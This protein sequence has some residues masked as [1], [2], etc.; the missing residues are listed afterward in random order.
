L[1]RQPGHRRLLTK[2]NPTAR[3]VVI[4]YC[5]E[6]SGTFEIVGTDVKGVKRLRELTKVLR[7]HKRQ[8][9]TARYE[10]LA[11]IKSTPEGERAIVEAIQS[12]GITLEHYW[13]AHSAWAPGT[14]VG[15]HGLGYV[16]NIDRYKKS[17]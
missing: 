10:V 9:P 14:Q 7:L 1:D 4:K 2:N 6:P 13:A 5:L 15:P 12:A 8:N 11:E 17:R 16:D 3:L